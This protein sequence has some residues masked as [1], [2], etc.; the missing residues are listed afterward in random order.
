M[1]PGHPL[2]GQY[3]FALRVTADEIVT[4]WPKTMLGNLSPDHQQWL[5]SLPL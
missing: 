5:G 1:V 4:P 2:I 3:D